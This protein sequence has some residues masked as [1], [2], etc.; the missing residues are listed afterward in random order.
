MRPLA[1]TT[2]KAWQIAPQRGD[3][4]GLAATLR[5]SPVVARVLI[6]RG[7]EEPE[8][9]ARFLNPKL[10][11]LIEPER[12]PGI[13]G[14]VERI[15][16]AIRDRERITIYGDYD[17]DGIAGVAILWHVLQLLGAQVDYYIPHRVDEGYGLN[18]DAVRQLAEAGTRVMVTVD[19]GVTGLAAAELAG[20]L[21]VDLVITD[22]HQFA[23]EMPHAVAI[24]HP[25]LDPSYPNQRS[26]GALVA[27]KVAWAIANKYK[28]G[29][30][31]SPE[32]RE[33][34]LNAT[35]FAAMGTVAD[36][37]DLCGE[38]RV[39]A[40]YGL[41]ALGQCKLHGINALIQSAGLVGQDIDSYHIGF[42]LAPMLNAAGRMG[43]ARL[44]VELLTSDSQLSSLKI[45]EY[46]KQQNELRR[47]CEK[48]ILK[49]AYDIIHAAGLDHPDKKSIVLAG[50]GWHTG[51]IGI[52]ASRIVDKF[53]KPAILINIT[54]GSGKGSGR[55]VAGF[56]LLKAIA[57]GAQYLE[58]YGGHAMAAGVTIKTENVVPFAEAVEEYARCNLKDEIEHDAVKVE[59][60]CTVGDFRENVVKELDRLGP[61][62]E[63]NPKPVFAS[64]GVRLIAPPRRVGPKG[65]HLQ[66]AI[67][68]RT[69]NV[70]CVGFDMGHLDK[71]LQEHE[72]FN[73]AFEP[74]INH[75]NGNSSV[76]FV[77]TDIQFE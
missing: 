3:A 18:T 63:G 32:L 6:N 34:L 56:D 77:L 53:Y 2:R 30:K 1:G 62:G 38:N 33:F 7:L 14:A 42:K 43:H 52:V 9:G 65:E 48:K 26:A 15:C 55:S 39:I 76:Q 10:T 49:E 28:T 16:R 17:V 67:G 51:V 4:G 57:A 11:D 46:L 5:V 75:F 20:E 58:D 64:M 47:T 22:H 50:D 74:A 8:A 59:A 72:F 71:K 12:M 60:V 66:V 35:M 44:A 31:L 25:L 41:R 61:F 37:M 54:N 13:E 23:S 27:F 24:V 19:C 69:G 45:A 29:A 21:G 40:S 68:D 73:V 36:V 70:R